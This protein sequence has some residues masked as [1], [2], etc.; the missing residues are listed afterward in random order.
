VSYTP[1]LLRG[2]RTTDG[3]LHF[4]GEALAFGH[5]PASPVLSTDRP[6]LAAHFGP[7]APA[8]DAH[9]DLWR[10]FLALNPATTTSTTLDPPTHA[11][12]R[13]LTLVPYTHLP[14]TN[15]A[16]AVIY[17]FYVAG[18]GRPASL[19]P[20][21]RDRRDAFLDHLDHLRHANP[22]APELDDDDGDTRVARL[23]PRRRGPGPLDPNTITHLR[24]DA[25]HQMCAFLNR[26]PTPAPH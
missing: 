9:T 21:T 1:E 15:R 19:A 13:R 16:Q 11:Y 22:D 24:N 26:H 5:A 3:W 20:L 12:F 2:T 25:I 14:G 4:W 7:R 6:R 10:A 23:I 17:L 18:L 8:P